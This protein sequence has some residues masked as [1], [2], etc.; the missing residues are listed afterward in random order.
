MLC[1]EKPRKRCIFYSNGKTWRP[2]YNNSEKL[3]R[4]LSKIGEWSKRQ[5]VRG[6]R[7]ERKGEMADRKERIEGMVLRKIE[8]GSAN[9]GLFRTAEKKGNREGRRGQFVNR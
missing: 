3:C 8:M 6:V 1:I 9:V 4:R 5:G 2:V 7:E